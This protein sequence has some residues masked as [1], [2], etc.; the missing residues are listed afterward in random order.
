V[1]VVQAPVELAPY[2]LNQHWHPRFHHD[3]AVVWIRELVKRTFEG[4]PDHRR[5]Q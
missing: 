3:P 4:Y 2:A 5:E 1:R